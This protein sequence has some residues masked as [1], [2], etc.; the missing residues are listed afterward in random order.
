MDTGARI[1]MRTDCRSYDALLT[2][3]QWFSPSFPIGAFSYSHG[4]EWVVQAGD[5]HDFDSFRQWLTDV[6]QHGAGRSDVILLAEA[7]RAL[8]STELLD[9]DALGRALSPSSERLLEI[10]QQ[11]SAF[12]KTVS[13]VWGLGLPELTLPVA[14]GAAAKAQELPLNTTAAM[15]LH[16]FAS[17]LTS[18]AIRLVPMGQTEGQ[19]CLAA[20]T[21]L[22]AKTANT[23][24]QKSIDDIGSA[25]FAVDIASMRHEVQY[26]RMFRS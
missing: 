13:D 16:A 19:R 20:L 17:S 21:P 5:V 25:V 3:T 6:V 7:F 12:S 1:L 4:L 2:L 15:F 8:T 23:A 9:I 22:I 10:S 24:I 11:G 26:S 18:A 14:F